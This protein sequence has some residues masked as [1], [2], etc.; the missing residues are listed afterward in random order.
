MTLFELVQEL[1]R[2]ALKQPNVRT[3]KEGNIYDAMN[4]K[5]NIKY[6]VF[7]ITQGTHTDEEFIDHYNLTLFYIDR[8]QSDLDDNRLQIQSIGKEVLHNIILTFCDYYEIDMPITSYTTFTQRFS[9]EC[10]GTYCQVVFDLPKDL[11]CPEEYE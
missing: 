9:D 10:A 5:P 8:L 3:A 11:L 6:G 1:T 2:I 7:F 4:A